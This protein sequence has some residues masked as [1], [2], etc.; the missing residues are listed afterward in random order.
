[1]MFNS[2]QYIV[3]RLV[4]NSSTLFLSASKAKIRRPY[5]ERSLGLYVDHSLNLAFSNLFESL[6]YPPTFVNAKSMISLCE[7]E[8][9][10]Q[11]IKIRSN[12]E[13]ILKR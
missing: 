10:A 11:I 13:N 2:I 6:L 12:A 3:H 7:C 1:M 5:H 4:P 9:V 8:E